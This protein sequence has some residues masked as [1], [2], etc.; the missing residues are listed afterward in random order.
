LRKELVGRRD[1]AAFP[2]RALI[3]KQRSRLLFE[4]PSGGSFGLASR[5]FWWLLLPDHDQPENPI[6]YKLQIGSACQHREGH[7]LRGFSR[8]IGFVFYV[9]NLDEMRSFEDSERRQVFSLFRY[10]GKD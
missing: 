2:Q 8:L 1:E 5:R 10:G 3:G 9:T 6:W 4:G 7:A